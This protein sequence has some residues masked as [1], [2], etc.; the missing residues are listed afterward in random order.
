MDA[1]MCWLVGEETL[2]VH[3]QR[4]WL[5]MRCSQHQQCVCELSEYTKLPTVTPCSLASCPHMK[6]GT[7]WEVRRTKTAAG[8]CGGG[9]WSW[10]HRGPGKISRESHPA[11]SKSGSNTPVT[12]PTDACLSSPENLPWWRFHSIL[13]HFLWDFVSPSQMSRFSSH[14][15]TSDTPPLIRQG[16]R[17]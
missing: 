16:P 10:R 6:G 3:T 9:V 5:Q 1:V 12:L 13:W 11:S 17:E 4:P 2:T 15:H 7:S 8:D 14:S